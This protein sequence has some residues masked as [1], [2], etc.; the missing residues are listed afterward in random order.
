V[1]PNLY[2]GGFSEE[3]NVE[4]LHKFNIQY[5]LTLNI[6]QVPAD[7]KVCHGQAGDFAVNALCC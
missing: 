5:V 2:I 7:P 6:G 3:T 4:L 1:I